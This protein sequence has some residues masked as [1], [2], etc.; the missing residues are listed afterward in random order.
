MD[1]SAFYQGTCFDAYEF[2]GAH[3]VR[4]GYVF[5]TYAPRADRV[6]LIG[7][8][9]DWQEIEMERMEDGNFFSCTIP[10]KEGQMYKYRIYRDGRGVDHADPYGYG[11]ELR[12]N[13]ASFLR[14]LSY[15]FGD[16]VWMKARTDCV[17]S[18]LNIYEI[19][20]GSWRKKGAGQTDWY[21]YREIAKPLVSYLKQAGYN[22]VEFLPLAEHS[23]D[24]SWG[25]QNTG[26]F[27]PTS[28]YGEAKDLMYLVDYCHQNGIGVIMD[29]VP[30][31]FAVDAYALAKYDGTP[32]FE[33]DAED[34]AV[35]EWGS[36]NFAHERG[37]VRSFL[38]SA[39]AFW[40]DKFHFDGLRVDAVSRILYWMGDE[41]RGANLPAI[42][43][44]Q[45]MNKGLKERFPSCILAAEDSSSYDGVTAKDERGLYFDYKWDMGWMHD[46]L[47]FFQMIP[48][49][50]SK[51]S[52]KISFSMYYFYKDR[53][54]LPLS[55]DEVVHGKATIIQKMNGAYEDK[56][57][58]VRALYLYMYA[59]PGKKL[60][61][62]GNEIGHFREWDEKREQDWF[63]LKYP[64]H[65]EFSRFMAGLN[66]LYLEHPA[67]WEKDYEYDGFHWEA[68]NQGDRNVYAFRRFAKSECILAVFNFCDVAEELTLVMEDVEKIEF[69]YGT[70]PGD[71]TLSPKDGTFV[72]W[73]APYDARFYKVTPKRKKKGSK[74]ALLSKK[75]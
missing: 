66:H 64:L 57:P 40:L 31:H 58:Q 41:K 26:F 30:V 42:R 1:I 67:F 27:S 15:K 56:F 14:D 37:E 55:H 7:E 68:I 71:K 72:F 32:L 45:H 65:D 53:F 6:A 5:R 33:P 23:C 59:H 17:K 2:L 73:L 43:F 20:L 25:Y 48:L 50:R 62:M 21:T 61:F 35:S 10:A 38:Q 36:Y 8:F 63:L 11:M 9:S 3:P 39:A 47:K 54:L 13:S 70:I 75:E 46:T 22:Y 29:F 12:P 69:L 49:G 34:I 24:E 74:G 4:D 44:M 60:N 28:R 52:D 51:N 16:E 19:H 18:A